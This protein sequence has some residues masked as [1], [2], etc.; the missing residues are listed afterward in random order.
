MR[1]FPERYWESDFHSWVHVAEFARRESWR[2]IEMPA[3]PTDPHS[4]R[5]E[6]DALLA[7]QADRQGLYDRYQEIMEEC[8][9]LTGRF[10]RTL[11]YR[12]D[13]HPKTHELVFAI[14]AASMMMLMHVKQIHK[15]VR[16]VELEPRLLPLFPTPGHPAYPSGHTT[17]SRLIAHALS[18][19]RPDASERLYAM[20]QRI[21]E[22]REWAGVH[23]ASDTAGGRFLA[24]ASWPIMR[25]S[26][27]ELV[28]A[29]HRE[30]V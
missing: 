13:S 2:Q 12:A 27:I 21:G 29:A 15:R 17:Q 7:K 24:D 18:E 22:N 4:L 11:M 28:E 10:L 9:N 26:M 6:L 16:P 1:H 5:E 23:Y 8:S 14:Q 3:F 30:W 19:L 20:A 25:E